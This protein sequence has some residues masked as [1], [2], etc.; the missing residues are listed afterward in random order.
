M[1]ISQVALCSL[2]EVERER[3][4]FRGSSQ[5]NICLGDGENSTSIV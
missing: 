2:G 1:A 5:E 3:I 4:H